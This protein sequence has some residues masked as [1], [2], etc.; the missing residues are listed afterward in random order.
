MLQ[1]NE[2]RITNDGKYLI[3]DV[4]VQ[5]LDYYKNV[6]I[7]SICFDTQESYN[8]TGPSSKAIKVFEAQDNIKNIKISYDIDLLKNNM[9]FVYAI[10]KGTPSEDTPCG[11]KDTITLGITY[12]KYPLFV[13]AMKLLK[14]LKGCE[15]PRH[16]MDFFLK[17]EA[18]N[19]CIETGN[20]TK[21]IE[22][23][24]KF[25]SNTNTQIINTCGCYG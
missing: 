5:N 11:M 10:A 9:F 4:Q 21:A 14:E 7:D 22:Y 24:N 1:F 12:Y 20:H 6:Y 17:I 18:F 15:V 16:I 8:A 13:T 19:L 23:W 3:I 2:L 25:Y